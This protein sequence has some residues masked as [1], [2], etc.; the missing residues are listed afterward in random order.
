MSPNLS[1][2]GDTPD[3]ITANFFVYE[4]QIKMVE[5]EDFANLDVNKLKICS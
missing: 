4:Q 3:K 5:F 2:D 1:Q